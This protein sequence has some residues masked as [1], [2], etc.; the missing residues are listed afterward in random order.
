LEIVN[1][2]GTSVITLETL[3]PDARPNG[4]GYLRI[5]D[6]GSTNEASITTA[7]LLMQREPDEVE[8]EI[9]RKGAELLQKPVGPLGRESATLAP[10]SFGL[11]TPNGLVHVGRDVADDEGFKIKLMS[12]PEGIMSLN[13]RRV[14]FYDV[15]GKPRSVVP[16]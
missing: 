16:R 14:A 12:K 4:M 15:E 10:G 8:R 2:A 13:G 3:Y 6:P 11:L 5:V 9:L 7:R 1:K